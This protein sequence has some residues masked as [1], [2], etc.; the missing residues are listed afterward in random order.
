MARLIVRGQRRLQGMV[1]VSGAKNAALP[2]LAAS[3]LTGDECTFEN[4][5]NIE[6]IR[7]MAEL[8]RELGAEVDMADFASTHRIRI[9]ARNLPN[10]VVSPEIAAKA[11]AS[12]LAVGPLMGRLGRALAPHPG[13]CA[14]GTRPVNVDIKGLGLM[15]AS[16]GMEDGFYSMRSPGRLKGERIYLDY[17]SHTGTE[18][19]LM[20][21]CL[22]KGTT[23][24]KHA[25]A[26]PEVIALAD[27]LVAMGARIEGAG[28]SIIRVEGVDSLHGVRYNVVPDRIEAG[29]FAVAA[30][31]SHG[32]VTLQPVVVPHMDPLTH[33][34]REVGAEV[35]DDNGTYV[36]RG[37]TRMS[38]TEVQ[39][40]PY[41]GF[42]TDLQ[43]VFSTLLTQADGAS[44]VH[45]RVY[46]NR[47]GYVSELVRMGA[48]IE[49][50]GQTA[51]ISGPT[52]LRGGTV[53]ARD[54][55][56]GAALVVAGLAAEGETVIED[57]HHLE[58]G[59]EDI[60]GKLASLGAD[61]HRED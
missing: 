14:I 23:I 9:R 56:A 34:L 43:A 12:F 29:T 24:I 51:T 19:L 61:I 58:R 54:L 60:V 3:I 18:N 10:P 16:I 4:V 32:E 39:T 6:D 44:V 27:V 21:A 59:Y 8:L 1:Q 22:A 52:P 20:A 15:G 7:T 47:L 30:A 55:R 49:V 5:P 28:T 42:P 2:M 50:Q 53:R 40:L 57:I 31:I 35:D 25:S 45:E 37:R 38:G 13:G 26:E 46:D 17:P 36:V 41:P 11:R 48:N 33:K